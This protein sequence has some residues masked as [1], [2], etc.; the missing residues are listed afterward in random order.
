[1][2][3]WNSQYVYRTFHEQLVPTGPQYANC[4]FCPN[5]ELDAYKIPSVQYADAKMLRCLDANN[6][7][8]SM[9][10]LSFCFAAPS[11]LHLQVPTILQYKPK[12]TIVQVFFLQKS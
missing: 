9:R 7:I 8:P 2:L 3:K 1:M 10:D 12:I 6:E 11:L 4:D 5:P